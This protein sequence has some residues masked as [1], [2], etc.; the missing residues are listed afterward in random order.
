MPGTAV[1]PGIEKMNETSFSQKSLIHL[2][3]QMY[4]LQQHVYK[5]CEDLRKGC[6][7]L[8]WEMEKE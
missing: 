1:V 7:H 8:G 4:K 2:E 6:D 3:R 5:G